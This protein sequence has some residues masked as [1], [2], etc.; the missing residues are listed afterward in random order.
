MKAAPV[1]DAT[2]LSR[3]TDDP[4]VLNGPVPRSRQAKQ[5]FGK[6]LCIQVVSNAQ[7]DSHFTKSRRPLNAAVIH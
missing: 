5:R 1:V 7:L 3:P 4:F 2:L 6:V